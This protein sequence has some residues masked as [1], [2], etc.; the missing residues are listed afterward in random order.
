MAEL[1]DG[2][3]EPKYFDDRV[4]AVVISFTEL[5]TVVVITDPVALQ[6]L[7][8]NANLLSALATSPGTADLLRSLTDVSQAMPDVSVP[9]SQPAH[10]HSMDW[11]ASAQQQTPP[12]PP[13][14]LPALSTGA[15]P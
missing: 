11:Q 4:L 5:H 3:I 13:P 7:L 6:A 1:A 8:A 2:R 9:T 14:T 12:A 10:S 15:Q